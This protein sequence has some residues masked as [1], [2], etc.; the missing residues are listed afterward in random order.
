MASVSF[1]VDTASE[2]GQSWSTTA[3]SAQPHEDEREE[4]IRHALGARCGATLPPVDEDSLLDYYHHLAGNLSFPF[5]AQ[6]YRDEE[7]TGGKDHKVTVLTLL[8]PAKGCTK[9]SAG[10]ICIARK[11]TFVIEVPLAELAVLEGG[12]NHRL[13][14][15]YWYW[16]WNWQPAVGRSLQAKRAA[17][18]QFVTPAR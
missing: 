1:D 2:S 6:F 16:F 8:S 11:G 9:I 7:T 17:R 12:A 13:A 18:A 4:R 14:E 3:R 15:D 5:G 10:L